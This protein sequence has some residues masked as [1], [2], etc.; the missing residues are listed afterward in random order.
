[1]QQRIG[2]VIGRGL[3]GKVFADT[4][5]HSRVLKEFRVFRKRQGIKVSVLKEIEGT[6]GIMRLASEN[7][8]GPRVYNVF[9][10]RDGAHVYVEMDRVTPA[11]PT[12][13][14]V[15]SIIRLYDNMFHHRFVSFDSEFA[16]DADGEWIMLDFGVAQRYPSYHQAVKAAVENDLFADVGV[17]YYHPKLEKHFRDIVSAGRSAAGRSR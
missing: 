14:D 17:G 7:K 8:I 1:M 2:H 15:D 13:K 11:S 9:Y 10:G 5:D 3:E 12:G 6:I 4:K 16:R